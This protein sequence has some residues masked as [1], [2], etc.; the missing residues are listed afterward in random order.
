VAQKADFV[1]SPDHEFVPRFQYKVTVDHSFASKQCV[2]NTVAT[3][4]IILFVLI[5][6]R[7][8]REN[9]VYYPTKKIKFLGKTV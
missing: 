9:D 6:R 1:Y 2:I 8:G 7:E 4:L 3:T 5:R